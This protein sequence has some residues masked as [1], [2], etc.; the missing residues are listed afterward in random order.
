M[1]EQ[2]RQVAQLSVAGSRSS[3]WH[4]TF[5]SPLLLPAVQRSILKNSKGFGGFAGSV[6]LQD[7]PVPT[8]E[9][10]CS[11][12][13]PGE[14]GAG[15]KVLEYC[16]GTGMWWEGWK[17]P[18]E[19]LSLCVSVTCAVPARGDVAGRVFPAVFPTGFP[20]PSLLGD[21]LELSEFVDGE[22]HGSQGWGLE[23]RDSRVEVTLGPCV[24][25]EGHPKFRSCRGLRCRG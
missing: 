7:P 18:L 2:D 8:G 6:L 13:R 24:A 3:A 19:C 17:W 9:A 4:P 21:G 25:H 15:R 10:A 5:P 12:R 23:D 20:P 1:P 14:A 22:T 11:P 16:F